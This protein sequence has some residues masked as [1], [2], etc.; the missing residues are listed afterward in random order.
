MTVRFTQIP[1]GFTVVRD[2]GGFVVAKDGQVVPGQMPYPTREGAEGALKRGFEAAEPSL[3]IKTQGVRVMDVL[4]IGPAMIAGGIMESNLPK[5]LRALLLYNGIATV[6]FNG[7]NL[8]L[9]ES[10]KLEVG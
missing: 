10:G 9:V 8:L 2:R 6:F 7:M 1:P 5:E 3:R 4:V